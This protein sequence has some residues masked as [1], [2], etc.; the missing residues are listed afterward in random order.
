MFLVFWIV[1]MLLS[2]YC[3]LL[4]VVMGFAKVFW[5]DL[6]CCYVVVKLLFYHVVFSML[7]WGC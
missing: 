7:V 6:A 3:A 4:Y 2:C 1:C 5:V